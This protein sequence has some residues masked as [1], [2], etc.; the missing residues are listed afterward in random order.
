[1]KFYYKIKLHIP[2]NINIKINKNYIL[3][4]ESKNNQYI[5][6]NE[7]LKDEIKEEITKIIQ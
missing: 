3:N 4:M 5:D 6:K 2:K 7:Y 1:M